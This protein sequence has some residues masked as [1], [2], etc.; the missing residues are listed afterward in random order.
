MTKAG[1]TVKSNKRNEV[2]TEI[3]T[4]LSKRFSLTNDDSTIEN[5]F[6]LQVGYLAEKDEAEDILN[7]KIPQT[8]QCDTKT[9]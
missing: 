7:E 2:K 3:M 9:K 8:L 4:C 6:S 5:N 1:E